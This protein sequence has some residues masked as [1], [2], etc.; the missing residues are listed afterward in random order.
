M[1]KRITYNDLGNLIE[2]GKRDNI[3][4]LP[5]CEFLGYYIDNKIV[6]TVGWTKHK[7][8]YVLRNDYVLKEHRGKKIYETLHNERL[9]VI[10]SEAGNGT[11]LE[12][13]CTRMSYKLHKRL[14]AVPIKQYKNYLH[15]EYYI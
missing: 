10:G 9:N 5:E 8:K 7:N 4:Y 14:G 11:T 1:I 13:R 6:G 12:I 2:H 3:K 15:L